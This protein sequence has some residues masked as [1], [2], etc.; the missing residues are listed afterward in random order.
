MK[1]AVLRLIA[2]DRPERRTVH[3]WNALDN[4]PMQAVNAR[5]GFRPVEVLLELQRKDPHA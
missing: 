2:R 1:A 3:T 5:L 4:E